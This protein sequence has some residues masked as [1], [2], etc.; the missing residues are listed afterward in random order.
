MT[1][2]QTRQL[3]LYHVLQKWKD[4]SQTLTRLSSVHSIEKNALVDLLIIFHALSSFGTE[5]YQIY[6][7]ST[8]S[9]PNHNPFES[10]CLHTTFP[11]SIN[12]SVL[13][14][15]WLTVNPWRLTL[16][17]ESSLFEDVSL[18]RAFHTSQTFKLCAI[19]TMVQC[20]AT[21]CELLS[22]FNSHWTFRDCRK[23]TIY[24]K[25]WDF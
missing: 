19:N 18:W 5:L 20:W 16:E 6:K 15:M 25:S 23:L 13:T 24:R 22:A 9:S 12:L 8:C 1:K 17:E 2:S 11:H 21:P 7:S 3:H 14:A 10:W 4:K